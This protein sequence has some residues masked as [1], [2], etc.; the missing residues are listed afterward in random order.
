MLEVINNM[1][2]SASYKVSDYSRENRRFSHDRSSH[3]ENPSN[4]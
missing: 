4:L 3:F 1:S 2:I